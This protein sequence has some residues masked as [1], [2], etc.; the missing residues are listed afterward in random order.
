MRGAARSAAA[1]SPSQP[2]KSKALMTSTSSSAARDSLP[3]VGSGSGRDVTA[4]TLAEVVPALGARS[5]KR[6]RAA[7][8]YALDGRRRACGH[9]FPAF[10]TS[11]W[12]KIDDPI[13]RCGD[14]H[15][16]LDD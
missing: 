16:V 3:S 6:R 11:A 5:Q 4:C 15:V 13:R 10:V 1:T 2:S 12:S 9:D 14:P 8:T 7:V